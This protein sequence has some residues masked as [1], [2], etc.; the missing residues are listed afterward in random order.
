MKYLFDLPPRD[1]TRKPY[2]V[3]SN[4]KLLKKL[5]Y[6]V[7]LSIW[8][9]I[10]QNDSHSDLKIVFPESMVLSMLSSI[11]TYLYL[12]WFSF[13]KSAVVMRGRHSFTSLFG[14]I[15][16]ISCQVE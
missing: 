2:T 12:I 7:S 5:D 11:F 1:L 9:K 16:L 13:K 14:A 3:G 10:W 4:A 8:S 6:L 15:F